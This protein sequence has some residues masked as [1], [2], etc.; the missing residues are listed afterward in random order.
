MIIDERTYALHPG[1]IPEFLELYQAEGY[2]VQ[3]S[4]L[5]EP[6]GWFWTEIG[7]L[8]QI[9][10]LWGYENMADREKRRAGMAAD[11]KWQAYL[12]KASPYF[13]EMQNRILI[14]APFSPIK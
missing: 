11:P 2:A 9:V 1:K 7:V 8:N 6:V 10:H 3:T 4:H 13:R 12:K 14:P 5:G